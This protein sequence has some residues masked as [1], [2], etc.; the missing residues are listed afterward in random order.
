MDQESIQRVLKC[1]NPMS[2]VLHR[3]NS[4]DLG[5]QLLRLREF[6]EGRPIIEIGSARTGILPYVAQL[7]VPSY[8]GVEPFAVRGTKGAIAEFLRDNPQYVG[9]LS[10][11]PEDGLTFLR[12]QPTESATVV[13]SGVLDYSVIGA[14]M[15]HSP[16]VAEYQRELCSEIYRVT[17]NRGISYHRCADEEWTAAL[18]DAG[19]NVNKIDDDLFL[20]GLP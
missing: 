20:K 1:T 19:F 4:E 7:E 11:V 8:V 18:V 12:G 9:A 17:P 6:V 10:A 2:Y 3:R 16:V 14:Y 15:R 13:S 5:K